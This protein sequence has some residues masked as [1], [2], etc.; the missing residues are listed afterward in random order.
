MR[1]MK[2]GWP[3]GLGVRRFCPP[4]RLADLLADFLQGRR[5]QFLPDKDAVGD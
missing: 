3:S 5:N 2:R 4:P 1:M